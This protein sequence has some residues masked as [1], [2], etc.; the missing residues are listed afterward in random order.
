M[1]IYLTGL[2]RVARAAGLTVHEVS[3]WQTR[4][5]HRGGLKSITAAFVHTTE[6]ADKTF[7]RSSADAPTLAY[8]TRGLGYPLYH[9]LFGRSGAAYVVAAGTAAHA[10]KGSGFG[11]PRDEANHHAVG[12]SFDANGSRHPVTAAQLDA[13]A[14]FLHQLNADFPDPL[15]LVMHGEWAP[16]RRS[17]PTKVPGGWDALR[18]AVERVK[19]ESRPSGLAWPAAPLPVTAQH[20]AASHA[21]WVRLM[22]DVGYRQPKLGHALQAWLRDRGYYPMPPYLHDGIIGPVAVRGLQ[23]FLQERGHYAG[24][25]DGHRGPSAIR[26]EINYLNSQRRFY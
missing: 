6:T 12:V 24:A 19:W 7:D 4:T 22:G 26:A 23:R 20:T 18:V 15:R 21:A 1:G 10:G 8:V 14:R 11:L 9:V 5:A 13:G 3:G 17:D 2:A 25:I 16:T